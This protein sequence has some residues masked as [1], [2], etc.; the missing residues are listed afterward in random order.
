MMIVFS[1]AGCN[2]LDI[3]PVGQVIPGKSSEYRALLNRA[4]KLI[5]QHKALLNMRGTHYNPE[6]DPSGY[7]LDRYDAF[8]DIYTWN[9]QN[10]D[11]AKTIEYPYISFYQIIFNTNEIINNANNAQEDTE[12]SIRQIIGEAHALRAYIFFELVNMYAPVYDKNTATTLKAVP[13]Y[14]QIDSEQE[15]PKATL[16]AAYDL[17][18]SDMEKAQSLMNVNQQVKEN[19]YR[20]SLESVYAMKSRVSLYMK[21]WQKSLD[22]SVK[23]LSI[24]KELED[25]NSQ[26]YKANTHYQSKEAM[27]ALEELTSQELREYA[28][29]SNSLLSLYKAGDLR[30]S[31]YFSKSERIF[32]TNKLHTIDERV[33]FRR[34]ELY[35]NAAEAS[36]HLGKENEA[37]Q[38][39][40]DLLKNRYTPEAYTTEMQRINS[41]SGEALIKEILL[42]REKE[43]ALEGHQ[44]Y[45]WRRT[46][47]PEVKKTVKGVE[48]ILK[49]N[50]PRYT[51]QIPKS[52]REANPLLND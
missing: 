20:F 13:L 42:E 45:D 44:W 30:Q 12:E 17:I 27:L 51:L 52:A 26:T 21:E 50:D 48:Y 35:L 9:D 3:T 25:M 1:L 46:G 33:S 18:L 28:S 37:R 29:I 19:K 40:S 34:A 38:Y 4:Y 32:I 43:L 10:P 31:K 23:S 14:T 39:L 8:K 7:G 49:K 15:F 24:N 47:Q 41:L 2:Y 6:D 5:P 22:A 11:Y 16:Q 36:A